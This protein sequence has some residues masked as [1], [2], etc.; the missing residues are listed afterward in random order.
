MTLVKHPQLQMRQD[1]RGTPLAIFWAAGTHHLTS[2]IEA[3][4]H[5]VTLHYILHPRQRFRCE[6]RYIVFSMSSNLN[7]VNVHSIAS[8]APAKHH[9]AKE[10]ITDQ[11]A[12]QEKREEGYPI[13]LD[14]LW[15]FGNRYSMLRMRIY[16]GTDT[17]LR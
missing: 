1:S 4:Q 13:L 10:E 17:K 16:H 2:N 11:D 15:C 6:A 7:A 9:Y 3:F 8:R 12:P 14:G 5:I